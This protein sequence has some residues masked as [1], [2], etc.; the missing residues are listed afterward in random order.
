MKKL[1]CLL[2]GLMMVG[3]T[4][5]TYHKVSPDGTTTNIEVERLPFVK[6]DAITP[7]V[8]LGAD[9]SLEFAKFLGKAA[10]LYEKYQM[11]IPAMPAIAVPKPQATPP[12]AEIPWVK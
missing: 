10:E 1:I 4:T 7:E 5:M 11:P 12:P 2:V 6:A 3:C 9:T 8:A